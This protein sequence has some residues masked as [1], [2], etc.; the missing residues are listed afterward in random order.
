[1]FYFL[2][3]KKKKVLI[4]VVILLKYIMLSSS[5]SYGKKGAPPDIPGNAALSFVVELK[6]IS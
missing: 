1:M 6:G 4:Q 3:K 5:N 2:G